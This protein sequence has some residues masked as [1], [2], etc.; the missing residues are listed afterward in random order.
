MPI[1]VVT[2]TCFDNKGHHVLMNESRVW[3]R[4]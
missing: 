1:D 3:Q 4:S 2:S